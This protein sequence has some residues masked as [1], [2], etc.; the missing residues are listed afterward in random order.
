MLRK[1]FLLCVFLIISV[2][3]CLLPVRKTKLES[4]TE[5]VI[6]ADNVSLISN[7]TWNKDFISMDSTDFTLTFSD[8]ISSAMENQSRRHFNL[9]CR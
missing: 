5:E 9:H 1:L 2:C 6:I 4:D 7:E 8:D 3:T